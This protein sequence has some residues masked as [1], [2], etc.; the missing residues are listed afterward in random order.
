VSSLALF[1]A[2]AG[3]GAASPPASARV[4]GA[5]EAPALSVREAPPTYASQ[6]TDTCDEYGFCRLGVEL[7]EVL[8]VDPQ[9]LPILRAGYSSIEVQSLSGVHSIE[10]EGPPR[11]AHAFEGGEVLTLDDALT[12]W[13]EG[14]P[15]VLGPL[16][17][18]CCGGTTAATSTTDVWFASG[19]EA[20]MS[21]WDGHAWRLVDMPVPV[22]ALDVS[23][24]GH[25]YAASQVGF[26]FEVSVEATRRIP[27]PDMDE[28]AFV[29]A[30]SDQDLFVG[31][32]G[33][34][35]HFDG[36]AWTTR[37]KSRGVR[38]WAQG[39]DLI[40]VGTDG[41]SWVC[42]DC[43]RASELFTPVPA[44]PLAV[45]EPAAVLSPMELYRVFCAWQG[46]GIRLRSPT[47]GLGAMLDACAS[48]SG[49][50]SSLRTCQDTRPSI[51]VMVVASGDFTVARTCTPEVP[52]CA[53]RRWA[54]FESSRDRWT[55]FEEAQF[56]V[57]RRRLETLR[58][59]DYQAGVEGWPI[60]A[61][62]D[63]RAGAQR[64]IVLPAPRARWT[65]DLQGVSG[66]YD[67]RLVSGDNRMSSVIDGVREAGF[68]CE[69]P[70]ASSDC[71][72]RVFLQGAWVDPTGRT[73]ILEVSGRDAAGTTIAYRRVQVPAG[74]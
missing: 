35:F 58:A 44:T 48:T 24:V 38:M 32:V 66:G 42:R 36:S 55:A 67:V 28:V 7:S 4:E 65:V 34:L 70:S 9:G 22:T 27:T 23:S 41:G 40:Q 61:P 15:S 54:L 62:H 33:H 72:R 68:W 31:T 49:D 20:S 8:S 46:H 29:R 47:D 1:G 50:A 69:E 53:H 17:P 26:L 16:P 5:V 73:L 12:R 60:D 74:L 25:A 2:V 6:A 71:R 11:G 21:H 52:S 10:L 19:D 56:S 43:L 57:V 30:F 13:V 51:E 45:S 59:R 39:R 63:A 37:V 14:Q 3:C 64:R 18:G